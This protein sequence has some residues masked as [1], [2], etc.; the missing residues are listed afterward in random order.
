M[1]VKSFTLLAISLPILIAV[2]DFRVVV[3]FINATLNI[4]GVN[5]RDTHVSVG[6]FLWI[7]YIVFAPIVQLVILFKPPRWSYLLCSAFTLLILIQWA[8]S[9]LF[10]INAYRIA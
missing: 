10:Y 3:G 7:G 9:V 5:T 8:V 1:K 6:D 2:Y 4:I